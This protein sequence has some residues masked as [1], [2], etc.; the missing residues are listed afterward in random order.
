MQ[1]PQDVYFTV[2]SKC[3]NCGSY[4]RA[5]NK[6]SKQTRCFD[7][8]KKQPKPKFD[9]DSMKADYVEQ[10]DKM[11]KTSENQ[12]VVFEVDSK[13]SR[14]GSMLR[15]YN[16]ETKQTRCYGCSKKQPNPKIDMNSLDFD[17]NPPDLSY[18][19]ESKK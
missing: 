12:E 10:G 18:L 1:I 19:E 15:A 3:R 4:L 9:A 17:E 2:D 8:G 16:K 11:T 13:C 6:I 7:C 5:Y 14:C